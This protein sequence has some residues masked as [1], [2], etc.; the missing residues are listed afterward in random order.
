MSAAFE[1]KIIRWVHIILSIPIVGY[2]YGPVAEIEEATRM[3]R[4]VF[5][6]IIIVS[7]LWLWK[8]YVVKRWFKAPSMKMS[9]RP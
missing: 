2:V 1:R 9:S 8:G 3:V 5:L 6:P 4:W 7:G